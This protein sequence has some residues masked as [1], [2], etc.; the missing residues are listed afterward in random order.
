MKERPILFNGP[1][2]RAILDGRKTQTRRVLSARVQ[3]GLGGAA[4]WASIPT[5]EIVGDLAKY[6]PYGLPGDRL[7]VRETCFLW[8]SLGGEIVSPEDVVYC[9][10]PAWNKIEDDCHWKKVPSIHMRRAASRINLEITKI[11]VERVQDI[12]EADA[13]AEGIA[14]GGCLNCGNPEPCACSTP[15]PDARDSYVDLWDSTLKRD[16]EY[17]WE[18]NPWVWVIEF[19]RVTS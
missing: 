5:P 12:T 4:T 8:K 3:W 9:E 19:K 11:R 17:R 2:V 14:D 15:K 10:D 13:R 16:S 7:W 6:C 18:N 1:M